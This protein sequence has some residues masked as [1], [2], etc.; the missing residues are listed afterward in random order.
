MSDVRVP[1]SMPTDLVLFAFRY[2]VLS[3]MRA[4]RIYPRNQMGAYQQ[5]PRNAF[6]LANRVRREWLRRHPESAADPKTG[7]L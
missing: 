3:A 6:M 2:G 5:A 4:R 7:E 1:K